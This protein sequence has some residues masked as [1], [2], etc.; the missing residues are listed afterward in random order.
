MLG[1]DTKAQA[2]LIESLASLI[3]LGSAGATFAE[4]AYSASISSSFSY[5]YADYSQQNLYY[6][7]AGIANG[8]LT[9]GACMESPNQACAVPLLTTINTLYGLDYSSLE[10]GALNASA[11]NASLCRHSNII[12][13]PI[14]E[15]Q[16]Y[17]QSRL[18]VCGA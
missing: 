10:A 17:M 8:N 3:I 7:I 6:D 11:G 12:F 15:N 14:L 5:Q 9:A 2:A 16:S 1:D 13:V 4:V 18:F